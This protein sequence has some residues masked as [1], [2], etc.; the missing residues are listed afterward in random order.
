MIKGYYLRELNLD[1]NKEVPSRYALSFANCALQVTEKHEPLANALLRDFP[2]AIGN[3]LEPP[4]SEPL[5]DKHLPLTPNVCHSLEI[6]VI[7]ITLL[8][9]LEQPC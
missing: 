3:T 5:V 6:P 8:N 4:G 9:N 7:P 2:N 1:A